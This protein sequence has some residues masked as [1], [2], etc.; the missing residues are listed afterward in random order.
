MIDRT[1]TTW[2]RSGRN[3]GPERIP[4]GDDWLQKRLLWAPTTISRLATLAAARSI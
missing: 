4:L 1:Y 2:C 3:S